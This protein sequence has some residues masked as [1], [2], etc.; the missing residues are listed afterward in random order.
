MMTVQQV[1]EQLQLSEDSVLSLIR[2]GRL[3]ASNV[4][5]GAV[6]PRWRID[7][8][9]LAEFLDSRRATAQP[10]TRRRKRATAA[11]EF[12]K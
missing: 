6:R 4:G 5:A 7:P 10:P 12:F 3:P 8:E 2:S 1:A 11:V 9:T